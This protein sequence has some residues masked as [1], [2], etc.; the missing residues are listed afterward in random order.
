M[1]RDYKAEYRRRIERGLA[2]GLSRSQARGHP[3]AGE[4]SISA[5]SPAQSDKQLELVVKAMNEGRSLTAAARAFHISRDRL[6]RY[7]TQRGIG[8]RKG[9][10]WVIDD[11]RPRRMPVLTKGRQR[12]LSLAGFDEARLA[13]EHFT[14]VGKFLRTNDYSHIEPFISR[15]VQATSGQ[16]HLLETDPNELHRIA[17]MDDQPFHEI[18]QIT[19]SN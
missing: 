3:R 16:K 2:R 5:R 9:R 8:R 7:L 12:T 13:G 19:S 17:A 6:K 4:Q 1:P 11:T 15:L 18:Y 10:T 14:A